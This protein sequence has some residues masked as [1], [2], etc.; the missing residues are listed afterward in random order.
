VSRKVAAKFEQLTDGVSGKLTN[1]L[2]ALRFGWNGLP[3]DA[4]VSSRLRSDKKLTDVSIQVRASGGIVELRGTVAD[5]SQR[6]RAVE[7]AETT[8]GV[9]NVLDALVVPE[10]QP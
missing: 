1:T 2:E 10:V 9:E 5:L 8:V 7:L 4:R 6:R 3:L